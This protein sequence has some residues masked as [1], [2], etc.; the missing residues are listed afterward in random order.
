M[1]VYSLLGV[2]KSTR[3]QVQ[4]G[5]IYKKRIASLNGNGVILDQIK[6]EIEDAYAID[7]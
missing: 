2:E 1:I 4:H 5:D 6:D 7:K 3:V